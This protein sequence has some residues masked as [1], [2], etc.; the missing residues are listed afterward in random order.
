MTTT[1]L[2]V[3]ACRRAST[4]RDCPHGHRWIAGVPYM[5]AGHM[6]PPQPIMAPSLCSYC[7][8]AGL[9][10]ADCFAGGCDCSECGAVRTGLSVTEYNALN[11]PVDF[12]EAVH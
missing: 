3:G 9:A 1:T 7:A 12:D 11:E 6:S 2:P 10:E 5:G 4:T 8:A